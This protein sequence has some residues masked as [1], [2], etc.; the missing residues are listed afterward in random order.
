MAVAV[1]QIT[2]TDVECWCDRVDDAGQPMMVPSD[3]LVC[4]LCIKDAARK[5]W[6]LMGLDCIPTELPGRAT[7][8]P[9]PPPQRTPRR[10]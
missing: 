7:W 4:L 3:C 2:Y 10:H 8:T 6:R 9:P 1:P 5:F